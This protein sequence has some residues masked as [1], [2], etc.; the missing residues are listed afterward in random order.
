MV[1]WQKVKTF[2]VHFLASFIISKEQRR[3]FRHRML[4][5]P[6]K[7]TLEELKISKDLKNVIHCALLL[8]KKKRKETQPHYDNIHII[9][10]RRFFPSGG[11]GGGGAVQSANQILFGNDFNGIPIKYS[12]YEDNKFTLDRKND[13]WDL[14]G[15]VKFVKQKT[16]NDKNCVYVT[17]D[18]GTAFGLYLL[19][20]K[21]VLVSHIQGARVEEK[22][23]FGEA[24]SKLSAWII[25][26]CEKQAFA[27]AHKVCFPS[28]GAY[29]YF[30]KSP[31]KTIKAGEFVKGETLYNTLYAHPAPEKVDGI[32]KA[33]DCTTFLSIGQLTHAKGMDRHPDFFDCLLKNSSKNIRYIFVGRGVLEKAIL[34]QLGEIKAQYPNFDY[35]HV[36]K[37]TYPQIQFLQNISDVYLMLHRISI[38]DLSTLESMCKGKPVILS[39]VGGNPEF[40]RNKNMVLADSPQDA[41][42]KFLATDLESLGRLNKEIYETFFSNESYKMTYGNMFEELLG[43]TE[44]NKKQPMITLENLFST[45]NDGDYKIITLCGAKLKFKSKINTLLNQT[46]Q[47]HDQ[48][49]R[50]EETQR[51]FSEGRQMLQADQ[52]NLEEGLRKFG[53][54]Q[55]KIRDDHRTLLEGQKKLGDG[56]QKI[57]GD[58]QNL[59]EGQRKLGEG[60]Q[61]LT[62]KQREMEN[63]H[64]LFDYFPR[65]PEITA[66]VRC[67]YKS[68]TFI[69]IFREFA[70]E[71][72]EHLKE[73]FDVLYHNLD[74]ASVKLMQT[75][76]DRYI[77]KLPVNKCSY[78][79]R[80]E[81]FIE[82]ELKEQADII[83]T[84]FKNS[85]GYT[86]PEERNKMEPPMYHYEYGLKGLTSKELNYIKHSD[87]LDLGAYVGDSILVMDKYHPRKILAL[88]IDEKNYELLHKTLGLNN[89]HAEIIPLKKGVG[90]SQEKLL[91]YG[92]TVAS[93]FLKIDHS[94]YFPNSE[95]EIDTIDHL[96]EEYRLTPRFI[97]MD[98][99]GFE[100]KAIQG[101]VDTIKKF[102]P[103]MMISIYHTPQDFLFI[104]PFIE[105]LDLDYTFRIEKHNPFDPV[106]ETV[107][108]A[109]PVIK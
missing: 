81:I 52:Q 44:K 100:F 98:V 83:K 62:D 26:Y 8:A 89:I 65:I 97:K 63:S 53:N 57:R 47:L 101:G 28:D 17:H 77:H 14:F 23:N 38:F 87:F 106:Y 51:Q 71:H 24:F 2:S 54:E 104:K 46:A 59:L 12:F 25:Q 92:D 55:Q 74:K 102:R 21:Y 99:E 69:S 84:F 1:I 13:L 5:Q 70:K 96:V 29:E 78:I 88:E 22:R 61:R 80:E 94:R 37:C 11:A 82:N 58:H 91:Y 86:L 27:N 4:S 109:I 79:K 34:Q 31:F 76:W 39:N 41:A 48:I 73:Y 60:Q 36:P 103:V 93:T 107:L 90:D 20:K 43:N 72:S 7:V 42:E 66:P 67:P 40:N 49:R 50:L 85:A 16:K 18:Y 10:L 45:K 95:C 35:I 64:P 68:W 30:C 105:N 3:A 75:I 32:E 33:D 15:A 9:T 56:Q 19:G 108:M 6:K